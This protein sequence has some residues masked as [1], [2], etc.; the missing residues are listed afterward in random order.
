[1]QTPGFTHVSIH[2]NDLDESARFYES[3]FGMEEIA[4]P[5]FPFPVRWLNKQLTS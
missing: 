3:F 1:M 5:D 2:A 4:S